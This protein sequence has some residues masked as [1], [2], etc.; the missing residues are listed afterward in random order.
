MHFLQLLPKSSARKRLVGRRIA[1]C[2]IVA[3]PTANSQLYNY[4]CQPENVTG[5]YLQRSLSC[6][7]HLAP[8]W[9]AAQVQSALQTLWPGRRGSS[10]PETPLAV[11]CRVFAIDILTRAPLM[12]TDS[13][14]YYRTGTWHRY[15]QRRKRLASCLSF[16]ANS[17]DNC[18]ENC[19]KYIVYRH[20][21]HAY[22]T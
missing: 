3:S 1:H 20:I 16:R 18:S 5:N 17:S 22:T 12:L 2:P 21:K 9:A 4:V 13:K 11:S 7:V 10:K 14:Q 8:S 15:C 19:E 6:E